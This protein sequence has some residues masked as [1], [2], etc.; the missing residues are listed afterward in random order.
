MNDYLIPD[1]TYED[2]LANT[3]AQMAHDRAAF[4]GEAPLSPGSALQREILQ[5]ARRI[6]GDYVAWA[7]LLEPWYVEAA[8]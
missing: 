7:D 2:Y 6:Q 5:G 8:V 3:R 4:T 1:V